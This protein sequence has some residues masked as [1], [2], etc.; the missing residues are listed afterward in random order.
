M[1]QTKNIQ[2]LIK[3]L[4]VYTKSSRCADTVIIKLVSN[5]FQDSVEVT[6]VLG[7]T[8][9]IRIRRGKIW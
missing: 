3:M 2:L 5:N 1:K 4:L 6:G 9:I 8:L 7:N